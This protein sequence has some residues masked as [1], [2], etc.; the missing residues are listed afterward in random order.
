MDWEE[1]TGRQAEPQKAVGAAA[2]QQ[3]PQRAKTLPVCG[4]HPPWVLLLSG[5]ACKR[6]SLTTKRATLCAVRLGTAT[7]YWTGLTV[8]CN[9]Q[10]SSLTLRVSEGRT[11]LQ[12]VFWCLF[13]PEVLCFVFG[14]KKSKLLTGVYISCFAFLSQNPVWTVSIVWKVFNRNVL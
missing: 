1:R 11:A 4:V 10:V 8:K 9:L 12:P 3:C 5:S 14:G 7:A 2:A 6:E 13:L